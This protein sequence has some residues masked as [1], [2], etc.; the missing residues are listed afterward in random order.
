[1]AVW[2]EYGREGGNLLDNGGVFHFFAL[3]EPISMKEQTS[4]VN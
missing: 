3:C 1:M 2:R 4:L